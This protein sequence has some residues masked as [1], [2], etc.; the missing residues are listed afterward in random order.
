[1][2]SKGMIHLYIGNGKGKTTAAVGLAIRAL[3][4]GLKVFFVQFLKNTITGEK[5][6]MEKFSGSLYFYRPEQRHTMFLW[7]MTEKQ[8]AET[9]EDIHAGW[10]H[11]REEILFG[12][13]DVVV[14]DE[15]LDVISSSLLPEED[16]T[17]V[18]IKK[19]GKTEIICTG[20][21][22]PDSLRN[23]ADYIS[24]IEKVRH[25][26]DKGVCARHGIEY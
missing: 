12:K 15:V 7:K 23:L 9:K 19:P 8:L 16:I 13:W 2:L 20:R 26:F 1:M 5:N 21:D 17:D 14:L 4:A 6:I 24:L 22:A 25:P 18:L 11:I 3:G 10:R